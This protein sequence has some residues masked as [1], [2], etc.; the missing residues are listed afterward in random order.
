MASREGV[1]VG[2]LA[3]AA[4][5]SLQGR[6]TI[7]AGEGGILTTPHRE[8]Y[9]K[10]M[11]LGHFNKR[12]LAEVRPSSPLH[13]Y[14][15]TG[16][17]LKYRGHPLGLAMAEVYLARLDS[18]LHHRQQ[19]AATLESVLPD[20]PGISVLTPTGPELT[21]TLYAFVFTIDPATTV[22]P[23]EIYSPPCTRAAA[24]R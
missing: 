7:T 18:W 19:H 8:V 12:A 24:T 1:S 9:E 4:C 15:A 22:S 20:R 23:S 10:A 2:Q 3:D 16:L 11:L 17:G 13:R 6:K 21:P 14:A 5:W